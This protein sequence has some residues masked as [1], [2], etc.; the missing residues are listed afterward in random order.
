[1]SLH[2]ACLLGPANH[3]CAQK[4]ANLSRSPLCRP[5]CSLRP[6]CCLLPCSRG[7]QHHLLPAVVAVTASKHLLELLIA[8]ALLF[9]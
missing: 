7:L 5:T 3:L 9:L 1:M 8:Q 4:R 6:G 2:T